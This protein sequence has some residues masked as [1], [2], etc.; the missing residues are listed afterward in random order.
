MRLEDRF[1]NGL[2]ASWCVTQVGTGTVQ[3]GA[4]MLELA[5][6]PTPAHRYSNAQITDYT[7]RDFRFAWR[8]PL[9]MTVT[10]RASAGADALRGTAGFGFWN[11]PFSPDVQAHRFFHLPQAVWFFFGSPPNAMQLAHGV[12]GHGWKAAT[13]DAGRRAALALAPF[14]AP[15][16]LLM[17]S[18]RIYDAIYP[19]IQ[20]ALAIHEHVLPGAWLA[21]WHTY[22]LEWR[23]DGSRFWVD[24][25][26]V[27][28]TPA[29]PRGALGFVAWIDNQYAIVTPQGRF[30]A[31]VIAVEQPQ[32]LWLRE[33][34]I[35]TL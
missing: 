22:T 5:V 26:P 16:V 3:A 10:A 17:Q 4:G 35:E 14:A 28:S 33:V 25:V 24:D 7:Y 30:G 2:D 8:P 6:A 18:R 19:R 1:E 13:L 29:A 34:V 31:G 32:S 23:A 12:P 21:E 27:F 20:R 11:H 9:R 15:A